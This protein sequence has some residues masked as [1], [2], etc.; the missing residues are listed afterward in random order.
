[1]DSGCWYIA[2]SIFHGGDL[3]SI[4]FHT[5]VFSADFNLQTVVWK[6]VNP[7]TL[8]TL[9][10]HDRISPTLMQYESLNSLLGWM[11]Y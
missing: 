6:R 8:K 5:S 1:M 4:A 10:A 7:T 3:G 2:W 9:T 11:E